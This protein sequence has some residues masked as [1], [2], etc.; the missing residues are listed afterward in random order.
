MKARVYRHAGW[1]NKR[2]SDLFIYF[3]ENQK[4]RV[5]CDGCTPGNAICGPAIGPILRGRAA[6]R[7]GGTTGC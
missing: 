6:G 3:F 4:F 5:A 2:K 7:K 1:W